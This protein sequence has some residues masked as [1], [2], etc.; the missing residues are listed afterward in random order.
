MEELE[1][2]RKKLNSIRGMFPPRKKGENK[3]IGLPIT[4]IKLRDFILNS[5]ITDEDIILLNPTNFCDLMEQ[6]RSD[7]NTSMP[8]P[9]K[10]LGVLI[11]EGASVPRNRICIIKSDSED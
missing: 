1:A 11:E 3:Y 10:I 7:Y 4:I 6:Y 8:L 9:Y 2:I 5:Q